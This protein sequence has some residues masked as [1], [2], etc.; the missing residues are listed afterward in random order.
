MGVVERPLHRR[1][2]RALLRLVRGR[3]GRVVRAVEQ[4]RIDVVAHVHDVDAVVARVREGVDRRLQEEVA[5]VL[6]RAQVDD[7]RLG[8]HAGDP[9]AVDRR[10][11]G[12]RDVGAVAVV[13]DVRRV[14]AARDLAR[15]VDLRAVRVD[16]DV[17]R[18]VAAQRGVEVRRDVRVR[19]VHAGVDDADPHALALLALVGA[20]GGGADL[21]HVPLQAGERLLA[22]ARRGLPVPPRLAGRDGRLEVGLRRVE[23]L[24]LAA[25]R[26]PVGRGADDLVARG[27]VDR[28]GGG[29]VGGEV[30]V[31]APDGGHADLGVLVDDRAACGR[32]GGARRLRRRALRVHDD[33]LLRPR[34]ARGA[35]AGREEQPPTAP[36]ATTAAPAMYF[37]MRAPFLGPPGM[38]EPYRGAFRPAPPSRGRASAG[39]AGSRAPPRRRRARGRGTPSARPRPR[40]AAR[41]GRAPPSRRP[42]T[43]G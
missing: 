38:R 9:E 39:G 37:L 36:A 22:L 12:R 18:E 1:D 31:R 16:R 13:V 27:A 23:L 25:S 20:L 3:V 26:D 35:R 11:D 40:A 6:A 28:G 21:R 24:D 29:R 8:R 41:Q 7:R 19:A 17:R 4:P 34:L 33:E 2:D 14:D 43:R 32:D 42:P 10:R 30:A 5:G 15:P